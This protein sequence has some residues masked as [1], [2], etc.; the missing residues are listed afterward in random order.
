MIV[1]FF[2]FV[3]VHSQSG[4]SM[5]EISEN[6]VENRE[7]FEKKIN[8][9]VQ[10]LRNVDRR[11]FHIEADTIKI[12]RKLS[13]DEEKIEK[14]LRN[15]LKMIQNQ[16]LIKL[17]FILG[18]SLLLSVIFTIFYVCLLRAYRLYNVKKENPYR[19]STVRRRL[20]FD[21]L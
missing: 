3:F 19:K 17:E 8:F 21:N 18:Y 10:L 20:N 5:F 16:N 12:I 11:T 2:F 1:L 13:A 7:S 9:T 15:Q 14:I 4:D 6:S